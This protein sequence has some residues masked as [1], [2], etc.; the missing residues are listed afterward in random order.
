MFSN[1]NPQVSIACTHMGFMMPSA[2]ATC[3]HGLKVTYFSVENKTKGDVLVKAWAVA[4]PA[5]RAAIE[6]RILRRFDVMA[7][8]MRGW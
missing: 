2:V 1:L 6:R 8:G 3:M 5:A 4:Q 7:P